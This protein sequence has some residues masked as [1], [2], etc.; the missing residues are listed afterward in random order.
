MS[1]RTVSTIA[2]VALAAALL[3]GCTTVT[4]TAQAEDIAATAEDALEQQ[5]GSRPEID[6]GTGEVELEVGL[7]LDC[8]LTDPASGE[9][10]EA[11][12]TIEAID[13]ANY[14]VGV[15]VG[16]APINA[17]EPQPTVE[18]DPSGNPTVPGDDIA[19]L[20]AGA[21]EPVI[22]FLPD[23]VCPEAEVQIVVG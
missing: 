12:V 20:A 7:V 4:L 2:T 1:I 21:L 10:F 16:D 3:A 14:T 8:V 13:G 19:D 6:C 22:G 9:Q 5:V 23:L 17:P 15:Q 11:P 18:P